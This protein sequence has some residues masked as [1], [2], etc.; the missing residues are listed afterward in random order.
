MLIKFICDK[1]N[2]SFNK[3]ELAIK[4]QNQS[5]RFCAYCGN[6]LRIENIKDVVKEDTLKT[7]KQNINKWFKEI[8]I[9]ATI[10]L[11]ER[12]LDLPYIDLYVKELNKRG[13]KIKRK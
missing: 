8:G 9:E 2:N 3:S 4:Q 13:F 12:H 1:C 10:E 7:V 11:I 5:F 6:K